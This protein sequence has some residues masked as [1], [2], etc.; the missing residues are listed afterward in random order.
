MAMQ[1]ADYVHENDIHE[2]KPI[3]VLIVD[4]CLAMRIGLRTMVSEDPRIRVCG[5][6][7]SAFA[8]VARTEALRPDVVLLDVRMPFSNATRVADSLRE[9]HHSVKVVFLVN[10][11][12]DFA[13]VTIPA[14]GDAYLVKN[15]S[16]E[17]LTETVLAVHRGYVPIDPDCVH[18]FMEQYTAA[19]RELARR[20][21]GLTEEEIRLLEELAAG[22]TNAEIAARLF[23]GEAT[24]TRKIQQVITKLGAAN[25]TQA[26]AEAIRR[27]LI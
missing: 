17:K 11:H 9:K 4:D 21:I 23:F 13:P 16:K 7:D 18:E 2:L 6:A 5:E 3:R 22:A 19:V 27:G 12:P 20:R 24:V 14:G 8:A 15:T 10:Q 1:P 25:R 26:T